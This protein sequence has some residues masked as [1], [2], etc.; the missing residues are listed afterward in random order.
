M[1]QRKERRVT[2]LLIVISLGKRLFLSW[3]SCKRLSLRD[4]TVPCDSEP[5][6]HDIVERQ[7]P[8]IYNAVPSHLSHSSND[9]RPA[10]IFSAAKE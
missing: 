5:S 7:N 3:W 10:V 8:A 9:I 2:E 4:A 1:R 6:S